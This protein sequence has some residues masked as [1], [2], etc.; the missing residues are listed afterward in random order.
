MND[1]MALVAIG[2][3]AYSVN[4]FVLRRV[5]KDDVHDD[6]GGQVFV[7][8]LWL[9]TPISLPIIT[10]LAAVYFVGKLLMMKR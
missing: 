5:F 9:L 7:G 1:I 3:T 8:I 10:L 4:I 2:I 6:D